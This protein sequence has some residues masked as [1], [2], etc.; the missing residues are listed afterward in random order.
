VLRRRVSVRAKRAPPR[1]SAAPARDRWRGPTRTTRRVDASV[2][3]CAKNILKIL[4]FRGSNHRLKV[5]RRRVSVRAKPAPPRASA[6][7]ARDRW[8]GPTR[9][10][11]RVDALVKVC[12]KNILKIL[13]FRG[14]NHRFKVLRRRVPVR[15]KRA[16]LRAC[17]APARVR[18]RGPA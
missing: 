12:A 16:P 9:T 10:T 15:A 4:M 11:R 7:P 17:A 1:A 2:K 6:A 18:Q 3:V 8:R 14:S 13:M 5:L